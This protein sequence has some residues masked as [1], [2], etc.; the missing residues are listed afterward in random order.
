MTG[1][2][3]AQVTRLLRSFSVEREVKV[4]AYRRNRFATRYTKADIELLAEVDEA[5]E[6]L[7]GPAT[8][9]ILYRAR[10]EF[11]NQRYQRWRRSRR[12][13]STTCA[14][15]GRTDRSE[16]AMRRRGRCR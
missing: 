5:H 4:K 10:H 11:G 3:R 16:H 2:R 1:L 6:T 9:K 15:A 12:P 8:Q 14:R 7:S 13:T